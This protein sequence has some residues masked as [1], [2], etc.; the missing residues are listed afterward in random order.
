MNRRR[1]NRGR[2]LR[3]VWLLLAL[4]TALPAPAAARP[5]VVS[6]APDAVSVTIYRDP[7]RGAAAELEP[8]WL[9]GY[10]LITETRTVRLPA[11]ES[12]IR[13]EGVAGGI[14]PAS[15]I[16]RGLPGG[17]GEKNRDARLL[18]AGALIDSAL[19][20]RVH[21]R[22]TDRRTGA[23]TESEAV[24]RS[25][26]NGV[27]LQTK[28]GIE[29]LRCTGL[30]ETPVYDE[31][32]AGLSDKPTLAVNTS[33][34]AATTVTLSLSYLASDFDWE[35][36]YIA[37]VAADGRTLDLF[38]WMT[39]ANDNDES[40]PDARTQVVAGKLNREEDEEEDD[41]DSVSAEI[42]LQC[43]PQGR[44]SD[45]PLYEGPVTTAT[46]EPLYSSEGGDIVVTGSR[47]NREDLVNN[48]PV[49]RMSAEQEELGDLKLY[50]IPEPVTV[51]AHAQK[52]V[53]LL[54]RTAVP[55]DRVFGASVE[56]GSPSDRPEPAYV[57]LRT[58]NVAARGLGLPLPLGRI[59]V[60]ER[61][62]A[63]PMLA[64]ESS[65]DDVAVGQ[66]VEIA[67]GENPD[68]WVSHKMIEERNKQGKEDEEEGD[69]STRRYRVE[70]SNAGPKPVK[71]E[72]LLL[73]YNG[74]KLVTVST[75]LGVRNG[76]RLWLAHVPA[77]GR[78]AITYE[79]RPAPRRK[80]FDDDEDDDD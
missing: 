10:A 43:W 49:T 30:P 53:A 72:T 3:A 60:F 34:P 26:P 67:A 13:F 7:N 33:S 50:R 45:I 12:E 66:E 36:Y 69:W 29:A 39:L 55:F 21:I 64:R 59:A 31:V 27:V 79:T 75:R 70:I 28:E 42:R 35:A 78:T 14:L 65:I 68:V 5:L 2:G 32:P 4:L 76:R 77:H 11:G 38:A 73:L 74:L 56:I 46:S 9:D 62:L 63:R 71:V 57:L 24:I 15:A 58:M 18:S 48:L 47:I 40:F 1:P 19:G 80:Y 6:P 20:R 17:V 23:V 41:L 44:T 25:G 61:G 8:E 22:R 37:D 54:R 51:A 16:V 52:Q